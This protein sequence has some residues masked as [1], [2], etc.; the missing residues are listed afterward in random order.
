M[1]SNGTGVMEDIYNTPNQRFSFSLDGRQYTL[2]IKADLG[3]T[4]ETF[5][6]CLMR[7]A[8]LLAFYA[9][10]YR[11]ADRIVRKLEL[12]IDIQTAQWRIA[13]RSSHP[14][15]KTEKAIED[16]VKIEPAY[17]M[18]METLGE[19][20][21]KR[22][23]LKDAVTGFRDRTQMLMKI[24]AKLRDEWGIDE[25]SGRDMTVKGEVRKENIRQ[26]SLGAEQQA[27]RLRDR[28]NNRLK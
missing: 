28:V 3:I 11:T 25:I 2:D 13:I 6:V 4:P 23:L 14:E 20:V 15:A 1:S 21:Y 19:E 10:L 8:A 5:N 16:Y 9:G 18:L 12:D 17:R 22:D 27:N 26:S 7:H 24:G